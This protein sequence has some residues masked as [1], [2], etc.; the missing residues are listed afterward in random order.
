MKILL[1]DDQKTVGLSEV[2][3]L[4]RLGHHPRLVASAVEALDS[5]ESG[6]WRLVITDWMMPDVDGLEL[7]R[8]IRARQR[9]PYTYIIILTCRTG[10]ENRLDL[11]QA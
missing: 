7:C 5:M 1:I 2:W 10:R 8:R 6:D 11:N 3:T 4:A 9:R